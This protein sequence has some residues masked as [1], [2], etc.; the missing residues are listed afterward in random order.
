MKW[1]TFMIIYR[2][3][4]VAATG[5]IIGFWVYKYCLNL[6][7]CLVDFKTYHDT[8]EDVYPVLSM[9]FKHPFLNEKLSEYG[10]EV[11]VDSYLE[12]F[13]GNNFSLKSK[14][15]DYEKV[16]IDLHNYIVGYYIQWTN[17]SYEYYSV[18]GGE[19]LLYTSFNGYWFS[20]FNRCFALNVPHDRTIQGFEVKFKNEIFGPG[21]QRFLQYIQTM[22]SIYGTHI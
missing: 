19:G 4:F 10:K 15:I 6:D 20:D 5:A 13:K 18:E 9:C 1:D 12:Y 16:T 7:L 3:F 14:D 2:G 11:N 8:R 17:G 21:T 22:F